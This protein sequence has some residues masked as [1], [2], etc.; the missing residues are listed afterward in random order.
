MVHLFLSH[1][2]Q[3]LCGVKDS[4]LQKRMAGQVFYLDLR[5]GLFSSRF[6]CWGFEY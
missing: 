3:G 5:D 6:G 1:S 2:Q 4:L